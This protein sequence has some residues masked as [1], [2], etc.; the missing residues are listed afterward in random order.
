MAIDNGIK[1]LLNEFGLNLVNDLRKS[2]KD[3]QRD[4]ALISNLDRSINPSTKFASGSLFFTLEMNDYWDA[5]NSG[6]GPTVNSGDG[7]V[8]KNLIR[9]IKTRKLKVEIS[10]RKET[11]AKSL[12]SK[13]VKKAYK[14]Q[15]REQAIEQ[16]AY[17]IAKKIHKDG[18]EGNHFYDEVIKDGRI[19]KLKSDISK[20]INTEIII[21]I[22]QTTKQ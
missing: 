3:K 1:D 18:Y 16:M 17:A 4:R 10:K 7:S 11:K 20:L 13:K 9:W 2:L 14:Q 6:R 15:T 8:R 19:D 12:N 21:D 5:V 22:Q